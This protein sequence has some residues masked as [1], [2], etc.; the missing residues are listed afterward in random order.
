MLPEGGTAKWRNTGINLGSDHFI[1]EIE[2]PLAHL[3]GN[4]NFGKT[5]KHKLIDWSKFRNTELG[6]VDNIDEWSAKL[7]AATEGATEKID[8]PEEIETMDPRLAHL[9]KA[10]RSL[11]N[12]WRRQ[13]HNRK[14]RKKIAELGREIERHSRQLCSQ[15]WFAL[16][17]QADEQL[18]HGG[19]WKLLRQLMDETKS[20]EY[21]RTRMAQILHTT[22]RQLGEEE[23]FK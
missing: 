16:C 4:P 12:R 10:R 3:N 2:L 19:T 18:H 11:Q 5:S 15:Q 9:L 22:A 14:L 8:A 23:M 21:Q 13:R 7:L 20:C 17:S 6:E 1:I